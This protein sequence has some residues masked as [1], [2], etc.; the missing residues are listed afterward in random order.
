MPTKV[1]P[2]PIAENYPRRLR[3]AILTIVSSHPRGLHWIETNLP[4]DRIECLHPCTLR[5]VEAVARYLILKNYR[6]FQR[7]Q[8]G[9]LLFCN[10]PINDR[11]ALTPG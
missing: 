1:P 7:A 4:P 9:H 11:G 2:N 3:N 10:W 8:I 6:F 5:M